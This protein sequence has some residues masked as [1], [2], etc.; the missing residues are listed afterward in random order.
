MPMIYRDFCTIKIKCLIFF[1][2][3]SIFNLLAKNKYLLLQ[4]YVSSKCNKNLDLFV[5]FIV[6][7]YFL[8]AVILNNKFRVDF[9]KLILLRPQ[10]LLI[11]KIIYFKP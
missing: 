3:M 9:I 11:R 7:Q 4:V 8:R 10:F 2:G 1:S 5:N 6:Y